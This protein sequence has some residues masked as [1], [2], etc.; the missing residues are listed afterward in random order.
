MKGVKTSNAVNGSRHPKQLGGST[1][2]QQPTG[3]SGNGPAK[4]GWTGSHKK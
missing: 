4:M 2:P 1:K 3:E